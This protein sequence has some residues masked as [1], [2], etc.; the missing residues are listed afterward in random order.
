MKREYRLFLKD[1]AESC[2]FIE[3]FVKDMDFE[4]FLNDEKTLS[5]VIRK[6]EIIGEAAKNIPD[7]VKKKYP[8]IQWKQMT[9]MRDRLIHGYFGISIRLIWGTVRNDIPPLIKAIFQVL[10]ENSADLCKTS[11]DPLFSES[12]NKQS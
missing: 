11:S 9:G 10:D 4:Q 8:N 3:E 2:I 5:A 6:L 1:I 7:S 12:Q